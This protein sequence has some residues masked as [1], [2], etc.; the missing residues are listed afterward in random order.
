MTS[1]PHR[2]DFTTEGVQT[3][4]SRKWSRTVIKDYN[5]T[6][7]GLQLP[8]HCYLSLLSTSSSRTLKAPWL[9]FTRLCSRCNDTICFSTLSGVQL[10]CFWWNLV[11]W[12]LYHSL[13]GLKEQLEVWFFFFMSLESSQGAVILPVGFIWTKAGW[14]HSLCCI[15]VFA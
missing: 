9:I 12:C 6:T 7:V 14:K 2:K 15:F 13:L 3:D 5:F 4:L 10:I 1:W 11:F 8:H